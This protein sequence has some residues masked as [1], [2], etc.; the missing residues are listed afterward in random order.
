M[1][2]IVG[3]ANTGNKRLTK[4]E[5]ES[6]VECERIRGRYFFLPPDGVNMS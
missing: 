4:R 6:E 1:E 3:G 5:F 2:K